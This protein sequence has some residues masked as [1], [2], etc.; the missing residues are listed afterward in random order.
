MR[1][2][3]TNP[4]SI[5]TGAALVACVV[6]LAAS[7]GRVPIP[8]ASSVEEQ[9]RSIIARIDPN[10]ATA[11][12]WDALPGIGPVMAGRIV[13]YRTTHSDSADGVGRAFER[14]EDLARVSGIGPKTVEKLRPWVRFATDDSTDHRPTE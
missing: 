7:V 2:R 9:A 13:E 4:Q 6:A 5:I 1:P 10:S 3:T 11:A 12:E 8:D 14:V